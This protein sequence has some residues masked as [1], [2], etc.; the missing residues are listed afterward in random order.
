MTADDVTPD[1]GSCSHS[2]KGYRMLRD[3]NFHCR[4]MTLNKLD[5]NI[6]QKPGQTGSV[7]QFD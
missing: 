4:C 5:E 6:S 2:D 1:R 3:S 7:D